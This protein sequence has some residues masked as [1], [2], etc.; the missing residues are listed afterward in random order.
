MAITW[1]MVPVPEELTEQVQVLLYQLRYQAAAGPRW[2]EEA[3]GEHLLALAEEPRA[4]LCA[5]AAGVVAGNPIEDAALAERLGVTVREMFGLVMEA[6]DVTVRPFAGNIIFAVS[7][8]IDD[9]KGATRRRRVLHMLP[10]YA[11]A[12]LNEEIALGLRRRTSSAT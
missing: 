9:G 11:A 2:D 12:A 8:E 6:N 7:D 1:V 10:S 4:L 3:M 5:V